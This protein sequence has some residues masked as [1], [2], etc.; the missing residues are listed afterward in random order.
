MAGE[1]ERFERVYERE[2]EELDPHKR[3]H[4]LSQKSPS[5][6]HAH[7]LRR[8]KIEYSRGMIVFSRGHCLTSYRSSDNLH[9]TADADVRLYNLT[10]INTLIVIHLS[11][12]RHPPLGL[13]YVCHTDLVQGCKL[14]VLSMD[15]L[16]SA[17]MSVGR[18]SR[19]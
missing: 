2:N 6:S 16:S 12:R 18:E 4:F 13:T 5:Q 9:E 19:V 1:S 3:G 14:A 15:D 7:S 11:T 10:Q 17:Q 8:F